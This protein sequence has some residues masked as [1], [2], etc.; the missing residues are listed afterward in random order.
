MWDPRNYAGHFG[1][2]PVVDSLRYSAVGGVW[3]HSSE[4]LEWLRGST[5]WPLPLF[6]FVQGRAVIGKELFVFI[7]CV[8]LKYVHGLGSTLNGVSASG[9][10]C[11]LRDSLDLNQR[12]SWIPPKYHASDSTICL[13]FKHQSILHWRERTWHRKRDVKKGPVDGVAS[14]VLVS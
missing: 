11:F 3:L 1:N 13:F 10:S 5:L 6:F 9:I 2:L 8:L 7:I 14:R 4:C 12:N